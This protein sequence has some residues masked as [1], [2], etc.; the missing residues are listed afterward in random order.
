M[1]KNNMFFSKLTSYRN[2]LQGVL[3]NQ[4]IEHK[5][6]LD[7]SFVKSSAKSSEK[8]LN[9]G[10]TIV[11]VM[12]GFV[13]LMLMMGMLSGVILFASNLYFKS[14]DLAHAQTKLQQSVY[15]N[16]DVQEAGVVATHEGTI[17]LK[18][19]SGMPDAGRVVSMD[20]EV[21]SINSQDVL[22]EDDESELDVNVF[23]FIHK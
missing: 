3:G 16:E 23:Y 15:K 9:E 5:D 11:E 19:Q 1:R 8:S 14:V 13:I 18:P 20:M 17:S 22:P 4:S 12:M 6:I 2:R 10:T 7:E 21:H